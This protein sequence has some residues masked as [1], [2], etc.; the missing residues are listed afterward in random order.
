MRPVQA[1]TTGDV[2]A[3]LMLAGVVFAASVLAGE[4]P[5]GEVLNCARCHAAL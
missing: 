3:A 2:L 1:V 4:V 5:A